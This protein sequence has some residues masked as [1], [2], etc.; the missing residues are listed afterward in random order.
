MMEKRIL[1]LLEK[2]VILID[3]NK[4]NTAKINK[5]LIPTLVSFAPRYQKAA[6]IHQV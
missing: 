5:A 1:R 3:C 4:T 6:Q 2:E